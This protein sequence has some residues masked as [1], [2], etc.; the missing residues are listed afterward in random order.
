MATADTVAPLAARTAG[1]GAPR[2]DVRGVTMRFPA[3]RGRTGGTVTALADLSLVVARGEFVALV[4]PSGGGKSTLLSIIAGLETPTAGSVVLGGDPQG[5][6]LGRGGYMPQR[7]L[8]LP[9]RTA[10]DNAVAGLEGGGVPKTVAPGQAPR[11]FPDFGPARFQPAYPP[12]PPGG[13]RRR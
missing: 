8:L 2:V 1:A 10:L 3:G 13:I 11:P 9:W 4:G 12:A 5:R 6:R 7:D